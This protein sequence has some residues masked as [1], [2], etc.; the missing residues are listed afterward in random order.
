MN[1]RKFFDNQLVQTTHLNDV[2]IKNEDYLEKYGKEVVSIDNFCY[3]GLNTLATDPASMNVILK[4][5]SGWKNWKN[6]VHPE[7][8]QITIQEA[9]TTLPRLDTIAIKYATR[10]YILENLT[11]RNPNTGQI[12]NEEKLTFILDYREVIYLT[13]TPA[14]VPVA[15]EVPSDALGSSNVLIQ[16][17]ATQIN[18]AD[19]TDIRNLKPDYLVGS[20]RTQVPIDHPNSS[21]FN[22]HIASNADID[23]TKIDG[24]DFD[25][26]FELLYF[27][28]NLNLEEDEDYTYDAEDKLTQINYPRRAIQEKYY[29]N[30]TGQFTY[31]TIENAK[32]LITETYTFSGSKITKVAR[33]ITLK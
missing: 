15:P 19:I 24:I 25:S 18:Q 14:E 5:G 30:E 8:Y 20:H 17:G 13:G 3:S 6:I 32:W 7:D 21:I 29:Y 11:F 23:L 22:I 27:D 1:R 12:Y 4:A 26:L 2:Q 33:R 9:H 10:E 31:S 28:T 16:A